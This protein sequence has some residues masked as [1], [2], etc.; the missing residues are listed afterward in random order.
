MGKPQNVKAMYIVQARHYD[1][2][3]KCFIA[4]VFHKKQ[5]AIVKAEELEF[6]R[7]GKYAG[8]VYECALNKYGS[9]Y[10]DHKLV[11]KGITFRER[12]SYGRPL[13]APT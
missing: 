7:G 6:D 5:Q 12:P 3:D 4:G 13:D 8:D 9:S 2:A 11:R 1:E 10:R